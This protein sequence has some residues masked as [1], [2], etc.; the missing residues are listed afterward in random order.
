[1]PL[2]LF[3]ALL[4]LPHLVLTF[5]P[6]LVLHHAQLNLVMLL[7]APRPFHHLFHGIV[8]VIIVSAVHKLGA[9]MSVV[10]RHSGKNPPKSTERQ[11]C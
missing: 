3:D 11:D 5:P 7:P 10:R 6:I 4:K 8:L 1:M 2:T 9:I